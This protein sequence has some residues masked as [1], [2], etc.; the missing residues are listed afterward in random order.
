M[1]PSLLCR[2]FKTLLL[3]GLTIIAVMAQA[4]E[5]QA[6]SIKQGE[7]IARLA[8]C[9]SCHTVDADKIHA[10]GYELLTPFGSI[11]APNITP[12]IATGIGSWTF[13]DFWQAMHHGKGA[14]GKLLYPAFPYTAYTKMRRT[15]VQALFAYLQSLPAIQQ[16]NPDPSFEFPYNLRAALYVWRAMYFSAG[17]YQD[18]AEQ[19]EAWN[20]GAYL[21]QGAGHCDECHTT[22]NALGAVDQKAFLVGG[23]IPEQNWYAPNLSMQK[24]GD[25]E[26]WTQ[27]DIVDL[28][29]TG[30]SSKGSALGPMADVVRN[31][32]QYMTDSDVKAVAVYLASLPAPVPSSKTA[33]IVKATDSKVGESIYT[34]SCESCHGAEGQGVAGIYPTL[35]GNPTVVEPSGMNAMRSVLLGGFTVTTANKPE[36]YSMP[37]F[38]DALDNAEIAAVINYIRQSWGNNATAI[39]ADAVKSIRYKPIR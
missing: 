21:V 39:S 29:K 23:I 12:D 32:T 25:L 13:D 24:G 11:E 6:D 20:R 5:Q 19:S 30:L 9:A 33:E 38:A 26:G 22:R 27:K 4:T 10:G 15:D 7:Y 1:M 36:P 14:E 34:A 8:G 18:N 31:S 16:E 2:P 3:A 35:V 37:P 28:L 17:E